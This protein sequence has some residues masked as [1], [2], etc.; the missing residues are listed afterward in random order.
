VKRGKWIL[1]NILGTPPPP[2]PPGVEELAAGKDAELKGSLRQRMEQH[3]ANPSC[4]SCHQRMDP[5]GF[6][7]ENFDAV[8]AYRTKDGKHDVD[9]GGTLASGEEF[10][11]PAE[12]KKLLVARKDLF[13]RCLT[14]KMLTYALGRSLERDDRCTIDDIAKDLAKEDYRM[15]RLILDVVTSDAFQKRK[16]KPGGG[17]K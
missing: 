7:F 2:P 6:G 15:S 10:K 9:S 14:E 1:E 8:G 11:G 3:R 16:G 13:A 17:G 4:A 12:L 5:I